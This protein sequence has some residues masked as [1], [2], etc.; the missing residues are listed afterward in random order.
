MPGMTIEDSQTR[1]GL[2]LG[3]GL[4]APVSNQVDF[5]G[6]AWFGLVS[7]VNQFSLKVGAMYKF[8]Q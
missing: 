6:E 3:G 7:D 1:L 4:S 8:G 5:L 2:D